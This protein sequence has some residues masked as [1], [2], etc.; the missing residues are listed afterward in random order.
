MGTKS[1]DVPKVVF[2]G[3]GLSAM[4]ENAKCFFNLLIGGPRGRRGQVFA[5]V[6][7]SRMTKLHTMQMRR[8]ARRV[9]ISQGGVRYG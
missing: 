1:S 2:T 5:P 6:S 3:S 8:D 9:D 4:I 7:K